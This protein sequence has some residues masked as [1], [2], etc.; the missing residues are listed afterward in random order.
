MNRVDYLSRMLRFH[1]R[2]VDRL[3]ALLALA[4][5]QEACKHQWQ[6]HWDGLFLDAREWYCASCGLSGYAAA[7]AR[8]GAS[9]GADAKP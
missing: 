2:E 6:F 8:K 7:M 4:Q 5:K 9:D 1:E 3:S